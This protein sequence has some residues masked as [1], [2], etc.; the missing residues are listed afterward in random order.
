[1]RVLV[2]TTDLST[3]GAEMAL[4]RVLKT[5][6]AQ[7]VEPL[8]VSMM[9]IHGQHFPTMGLPIY[10]LEMPRAMLTWRGVMKLRAIVREFK[11]DLIQGWMYQS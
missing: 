8:V 10:S 7:G 2:L 5:L 6:T 11:P 1:M 3:G 9:G 4:F